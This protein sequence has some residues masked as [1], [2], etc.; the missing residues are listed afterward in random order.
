M[1]QG[2]YWFNGA[3]DYVPFFFFVL[4]N[5]ALCLKYICIEQKNRWLIACCILSFLISGGNHVTGFM[6]ILLLAGIGGWSVYNDKK[7]WKALL[8]LAFAVAGY[9]IMLVAPGTSVRQSHFTKPGVLATLIQSFKRT[10]TFTGEY[11]AG[12]CFFYVLAMF[13]FALFTY[14]KQNFSQ[15]SF[16]LSPFVLI[17]YAWGIMWGMLCAP[18]YAT[19][20]FGEGRLWN[21]VWMY[22]IV[23]IGALVVYSTWYVMHK[24][25]TTRNLESC[26]FLKVVFVASVFVCVFWMNGNY[27]E[28]A[29][30]LNN[31]QAAAYAASFDERIE[32]M[33]N[34]DEGETLYVDPL[35]ESKALRFDDVTTDETDWRNGGWFDYYGYKIAI[36]E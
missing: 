11:C 20:C 34:A 16:K 28:A 9:I 15:N 36:R 17:L 13:I 1:V 30:E 29:R 10:L 32:M 25:V 26:S 4:V 12:N 24:H 31:G 27:F 8:P 22:E 18:Y 23:A 21:V 19:A 35:P 7:K 3:T 5:I 33:N 2:I 14:K 6:N